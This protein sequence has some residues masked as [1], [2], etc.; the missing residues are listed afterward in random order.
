MQITRRDSSALLGA[1]TALIV[2]LGLTVWRTSA[3]TAR[4][5]A[6]QQA[7]TPPAPIPETGQ[8]RRRRGEE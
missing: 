8:M 7:Q 5:A 6:A 4:F 2:V 3:D 1:V